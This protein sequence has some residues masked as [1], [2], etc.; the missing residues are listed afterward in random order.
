MRGYEHK[1]EA[2][3]QLGDAQKQQ[4]KLHFKKVQKAVPLGMPLG[5]DSKLVSVGWS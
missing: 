3:V 1:A 5:W 4:K 2:L